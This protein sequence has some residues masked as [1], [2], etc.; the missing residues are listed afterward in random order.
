MAATTPLRDLAEVLRDGMFLQQS[1]L[2]VLKDGPKTIPE[3]AQALHRPTREVTLWVMMLRRYGQVAD[4]P[5]GATDDY[6]QYRR[7]GGSP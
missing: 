7:V 1:L 6:H 2:E 3:I 5:K 4:V